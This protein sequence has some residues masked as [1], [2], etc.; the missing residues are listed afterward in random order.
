M[1]NWK[2]SEIVRGKQD[3]TYNVPTAPRLQQFSVFQDSHTLK[4]TYRLV[5][6]D[7]LYVN[8][9]R[10]LHESKAKMHTLLSGLMTEF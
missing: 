3:S 4:G 10:W 6:N 2:H 1:W 5:E 8:R 9:V 7:D